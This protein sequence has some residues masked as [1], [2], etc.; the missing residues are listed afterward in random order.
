[1]VHQGSIWIHFRRTA[2]A[3]PL[4]RG[5]SHKWSCLSWV[6]IGCSHLSWFVVF[7][8]RDGKHVGSEWFRQKSAVPSVPSPFLIWR[9]GIKVSPHAGSALVWSNVTRLHQQ[10][11]ALGRLERFLAEVD[12]DGQPQDLVEHRA[13]CFA[14]KRIV[15]F[16]FI[17]YT[18]TNYFFSN[19]Q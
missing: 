9:L 11:V 1:M 16:C 19:V 6:T 2:A 4:L 10:T 13:M 7:Y 8:R 18:A 5:T 15:I 12:R 14:C 3:K 17:Q